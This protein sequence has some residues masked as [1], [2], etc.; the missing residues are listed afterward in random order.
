MKEMSFHMIDDC[1]SELKA[2]DNLLSKY[3]GDLLEENKDSFEDYEG[4]IT[5][6]VQDTFAKIVEERN[7]G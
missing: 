2:S 5:H 4:P 6:W 1:V 7:E 3:I